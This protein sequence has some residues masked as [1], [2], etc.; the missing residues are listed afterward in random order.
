MM[1]S[2]RRIKNV[3]VSYQ[4]QLVKLNRPLRQKLL[5]YAL[6]IA[7]P[8]QET[9]ST[10]DQ[11]M[12][13]YPLW[14]SNITTNDYYRLQVLTYCV[15]KRKFASYDD[16]PKVLFY[17]A[18]ARMTC[19]EFLSHHKVV[20]HRKYF[21]LWVCYYV[22]TIDYVLILIKMDSSKLICSH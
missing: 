19:W 9:L 11:D 3:S 12:L 10:L 18:G 20:R 21:K 1:V 4:Q 8:C 22:C 7:K 14:F 2:R 6:R 13:P 15:F 5:Q 17:L 16:T